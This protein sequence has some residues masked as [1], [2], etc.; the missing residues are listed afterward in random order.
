M[1]KRLVVLVALLA[2]GSCYPQGNNKSALRH[3][4]ALSLSV[5]LPDGLSVSLSL[6]LSA[7][8]SAALSPA[9]WA[10]PDSLAER[11]SALHGHAHA[12]RMAGVRRSQAQR[13]PP[14]ARPPMGG[15]AAQRLARS[16]R[17]A[18]GPALRAAERARFV[19]DRGVRRQGLS[20]LSRRPADQRMDAALG[21]PPARTP[22]G[23]R[24][25]AMA[26][27]AGTA[28]PGIAMPTVTTAGIEATT[29][30][31]TAGGPST[32]ARAAPPRSARRWRR[33]WRTIATW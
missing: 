13:A 8:L 18:R 28:T 12:R 24:A 29:A 26:I 3:R 21:P 1:V 31:T 5:A 2:L 19:P 16:A 7:W 30:A 33:R 15:G 6:A 27:R 32:A 10:R 23:G 4:H 17:R 25:G 22:N 14:P 9:R 11:R 20:P